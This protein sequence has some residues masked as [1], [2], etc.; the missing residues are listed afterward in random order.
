MAMEEAVAINTGT[1]Q[2][3]N[4]NL[5]LTWSGLSYSIMDKKGEKC[6]LSPQD[7][8]A[9]PGGLLAL[10]GPSGS[11]KTSLLNA[12]AD[13]L[14]LGKGAQVTGRVELNGVAKHDLPCPFADLSAYVEQEDVLYALSTAQETLD[15]AARLRLPRSTTT[16]DR[17]A[18][19][20]NVLQH[21]GLVHV[22]D[23]NVGGSSFNGAV[24]GL[25]GGER[26]RLSIAIELLH[27]PKVIFLDEPTTGLDSYQALNV[28][29]KLRALADDGHTVVV[30]IHQPRSSIFAMLTGVYLLAAGHP[31]YA[32]PTGGVVQ[33]FEGHGH[34]LPP[35][36]NP[37]DF[38]IDLVSVDQRDPQE[39]TRTE[40]QLS[41]LQG[42][43]AAR[44]AHP[45]EQ[46][47]CAPASNAAMQSILDARPEK[48]AG[49][50][51]SL[52]PLLLL[53]KRGWREQ[54]RD[55]LSICIKM[56][57]NAFFTA[58]FGFVYFRLGRDQ[59]SIQDRMG[60]LFFLTMNQ[61][62]GSVIGCSQVIPRQLV[63][64]NRERSNR[65]Y[66]VVHFYLSSLIVM[67][68]IELLPQLVNNA[69]IFF[70]TN[71]QGSFSVFFG[72]MLLENIA[73][74][75]LGMFLSCIF[76]NVQM[77]SQ[78]A[79]AVVILFLMFSGFLINEDSVPVYFLWLQEV[80]FIRYAFKAVAVNELKGATFNC[81]ASD[82]VCTRDGSQVLAQLG[83]ASEGLI[84][85]CI[86]ALVGILVAFNILAFGVL[87]LR[88]P[89]FLK[90]QSTNEKVVSSPSK[91]EE[92]TEAIGDKQEGD[93][94]LE[95]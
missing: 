21:L 40:K 95:V 29:E 2:S 39:Q 90:L 84:L 67:I 75:S 68:P 61:A 57:F 81:G 3:D 70:M 51:C 83:F 20:E 65:L 33:Y 88:R 12:L 38:L 43:W 16:R 18:R 14:P 11:G 66:A 53:L 50:T 9:N 78:L 35:Q 92:K 23:T 26:K 71:L 64:V 7:G 32:G 24:R 93:K 36:F 74:I 19:I 79:P 59:K 27:N 63:I 22:R 6:I 4:I 10:M 1:A 8:Q 28:M 76:K 89:R 45:D 80:S 54:M 25:S 31:V 37:A 69:L 48:P 73:G 60:L 86:L 58:I 85:T 13:R 94:Q 82:E 72:V 55:K 17:S 62:F 52:T 87:V 30:S 77:A 91:L 56:I 34:L 41:S 42:L 5:R 15:F 47:D 44:P 49:Q 46:A